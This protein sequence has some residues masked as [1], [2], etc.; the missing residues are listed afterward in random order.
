M[1]K[2]AAQGTG[3]KAGPLIISSSRAVLYADSQADS[4][5]A[6]AKAAR[7]VAQATR[8]QLQEAL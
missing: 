5:E 6:C 2:R 1:P 8:A 4:P 7:R 3:S